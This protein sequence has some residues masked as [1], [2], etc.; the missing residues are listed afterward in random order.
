M[1][2]NEKASSLFLHHVECGR[3]PSSELEEILTVLSERELKVINMRWGL[4]DETGCTLLAVAQEFGYT[5][6]RIR[7]IQLKA[8]HKLQDRLITP[9]KPEKRVNNE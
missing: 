3:D 5:R 9:Q 2:K 8:I 4:E 1:E 6:E 7:Q